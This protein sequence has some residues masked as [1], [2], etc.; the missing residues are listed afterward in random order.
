MSTH[1]RHK[2]EERVIAASPRG[3]WAQGW[4][5]IRNHSHPPPW[6][7]FIVTSIGYYLLGSHS[8]VSRTEGAHFWRGQNLPARISGP[9]LMRP[10]CPV[11]RKNHPL[12]RNGILSEFGH[13]SSLVVKGVPRYSRKH[14]HESQQGTQEAEQ[15]PID[16]HGG[17]SN[18]PANWL[19][20]TVFSVPV[21]APASRL[22]PSPATLHQ[23]IRKRKTP[24]NH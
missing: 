16:L 9:K 3:F 1:T 22:G 19:G 14:N 8:L 24:C 17:G 10:L 7:I 5:S 6:A 21:F 23:P 20:Q 11:R 4:K 13:I 15:I 2:P 12:F 18:V